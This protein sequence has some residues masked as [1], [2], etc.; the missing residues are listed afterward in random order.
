A[1]YA[2][3]ASWAWPSRRRHTPSTMPPCR[4]TR[5]V[6]AASLR[7]R[8]NALRRSSSERGTGRAFRYCH[9]DRIE[10]NGSQEGTFVSLYYCPERGGSVQRNL[11]ILWGTVCAS[12]GSRAPA[13]RRTHETCTET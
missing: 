8:T 10:V 11:G 5:A 6:N 7:S 12:H 9:R 1:W 4:S 13:P 2:S 3:S